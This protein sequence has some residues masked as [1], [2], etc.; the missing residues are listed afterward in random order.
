MNECMIGECM[1][2]GNKEG[3]KEEEKDKRNKEAV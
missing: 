2:V 3:R 1:L